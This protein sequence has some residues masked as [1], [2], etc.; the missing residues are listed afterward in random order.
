M[1]VLKPQPIPSAAAPAMPGSASVIAV[2]LIQQVLGALT[3]PVAKFGLRDLDPLVF[4]FYRFVISAVILLVLNRIRG[5]GRRITRPDALKIFG[6]GCLIIPFNQA[7]YLYGQKLTGA[8][9]GALLFATVPIWIFLGGWLFLGERFVLRRA[10]GTA[11]GL[12]G[13]LIVV[14]GGAIE[15]DRDYLL[16]DAIILV[17]VLVWCLYTVLG[18]PLVV[19]YGAFRVTAYALASGTAVYFPFGL[20]RAW[21]ADYGA[22]GTGTWLSLLY[23]AVGTSVFSYVLWYWLVK[24]LEITRIAVFHNLQPLVAAAVAFLFLGEPV[25]LSFLLGGLVV[26]TGV[27]VTEIAPGR[28]GRTKRT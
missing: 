3:F 15:I 27:M 4:A 13:V 28:G 2:L 12:V 21:T 10:L 14:R 7:T 9:H 11:V 6:L 5:R 20:W 19:R 17:A 1:N 22:V 25:T 16:G 23:V 8:G 18:K 24:H 26:L